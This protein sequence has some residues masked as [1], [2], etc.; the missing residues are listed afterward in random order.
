MK[1][2]NHFNIEVV[3][4]ISIEG[5]KY[6][7]RKRVPN[8]EE[9]ENSQFSILVM[10]DKGDVEYK[11]D[12]II[13]EVSAIKSAG[14]DRADD[15]EKGDWTISLAGYGAVSVAKAELMKEA[16]EIA[17]NESKIIRFDSSEEC[18]ECGAENDGECEC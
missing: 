12:D 1:K 11:Y 15:I 4:T 6:T 17:I 13:L 5:V 10:V 9:L 3:K 7:L 2:D 8:I 18:P 14:Y 16:L